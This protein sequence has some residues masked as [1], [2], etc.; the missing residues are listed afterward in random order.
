[1]RPSNIAKYLEINVIS[2]LPESTIPEIQ[3]TIG[4]PLQYGY[5]TKITPHFQAP[6]PKVDRIALQAQVENG[7]KPDW[8][9]IGFNIQSQNKVFDI[10]VMREFAPLPVLLSLCLG[11]SHCDASTQSRTTRNI[12]ERGQVGGPLSLPVSSLI[13]LQNYT[14]L[15]KRSDALTSRVPGHLG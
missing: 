13:T 2:G 8:L 14:H 9:Q 15:Q 11:M 3:P 7:D 10:E 6:P 1:M 12:S 4:S 5:R